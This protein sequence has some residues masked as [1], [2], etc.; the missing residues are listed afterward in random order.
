MNITVDVGRDL[1][2]LV[3]AGEASQDSRKLVDEYARVHPEFARETEAAC[4]ALPAPPAPPDREMETLRRT[5]A[6]LR[7]KSWLFGLALALTL[8]PLSFVFGNGE[9]RF[10][11]FRDAPGAAVGLWSTAVAG[12]VAFYVIARRVRASGL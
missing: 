1:F 12:W 10:L 11:L 6:M 5:K 3:Q 8:A 7:L 4:A 2:A 9:I